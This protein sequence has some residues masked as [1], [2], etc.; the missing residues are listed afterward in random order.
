MEK[1]WFL[2][3]VED[4]GYLNLMGISR[5]GEQMRDG[6]ATFATTPLSCYMVS[7]AVFVLLSG[8]LFYITR[9]YEFRLANFWKVAIVLFVVTC[10]YGSFFVMLLWQVPFGEIPSKLREGT[11]GDSFGTLNTLFSGLAFSGVI[12]SLFLQRK[13]LSAAREQER[14]QQIESQFY[15][16][17]T[18]QQAVVSGFDLQSRLKDGEV[19]AK[20]R[21]C[22]REWYGS[23]REIYSHTKDS[24][25]SGYGF[26]YYQLRQVHAGDLGLY[27][28]SL[29]AVFRYA[30]ECGHE[31]KEAF[32]RVARSLLSD[33]ELVLLFY[34]C[35]GEHGVNFKVLSSEFFLFDNLEVDHLLDIE[36]VLQIE[37]RAFGR[38]AKALKIFD[39][40]IENRQSHLP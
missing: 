24:A 1:N 22:F 25:V 10:V 15:N 32:G 40:L 3:R 38:N 5:S 34:N 28:R 23:L 6:L 2:L 37:R 14:Q 13:D 30:S 19:I 36:D 7:I 18:L 9:L 33:Y 35:L 11:F 27:F 8:I 26:A 21:D 16:M 31:K 12:I 29:Y 39:E 4:L 20:G 17:L